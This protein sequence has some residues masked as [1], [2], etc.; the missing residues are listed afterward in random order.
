MQRGEHL[1]SRANLRP[2]WRPGQSG[3]PAGRPEHVAPAPG[4][5]LVFSAARLGFTDEELM[6]MAATTTTERK[7]PGLRCSVCLHENLPVIDG[8]L[9]LGTPLRAVAGGYALTR[10]ALD[11]HRRNHLPRFPADGE[12]RA[13]TEAEE[14]LPS[15]IETLK[16]ADRYN[17]QRSTW[18]VFNRLWEALESSLGDSAQDRLLLSLA[19]ACVWLYRVQEHNDVREAVRALEAWWRKGGTRC[20]DKA[21]K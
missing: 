4:E 16:R 3:N 10:S 6:A 19:S 20:A 1:H 7:P 14:L 18:P 2:P 9:T 15:M 12:A 13:V 17:L 21:G 5:P 8:L 11:R